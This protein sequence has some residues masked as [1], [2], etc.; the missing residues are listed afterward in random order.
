MTGRS[1]D[2]W[3]L[4]VDFGTTA[5]AAAMT[6]GEKAEVVDIDNAPRMPSMVCWK[7]P[8]NGNPGQ[9]LLGDAAENEAVLAP[10]CAERSPKRKIAQEF[11]LL[12]SER[13]R[14]TDAIGQIFEHVLE[15][16]VP[17]HGG[18]RPDE[19]RV[20]HP[21]RWG[22]GRLARLRAA[23]AAAGFDDPLLVPEP[24]GAAV[25]FAA[26]QLLP[27]DYVAV[28]D[29]GGGT[30]DTA[31]LQRAEIGFEVIGEPGGRDDLG[32]E[33][34]D[35]RLYRY[36]GRRLD[37]EQW[38]TL[39]A[40]DSGRS[41]QRA[42]YDFKQDVRRAKEHLSRYPD[43]TVRT[44]IPDGEDIQVSRAE[45]EALIREDIEST[46]AELER[47]VM[48]AG[49]SVDDLAAIYVAGG[50]S[51]IPLIWRR[52]EERLGKQPSTF[53]DPKA[54]I[55]L[56][57]AR[58]HLPTSP[59]PVDRHETAITGVG[60]TPPTPITGNARPQDTGEGAVTGKPE[61][62]DRASALGAALALVGAVV[63]LLSEVLHN[64]K[65]K[66]LWEVHTQPNS[67]I[68]YPIIVTILALLV[69][70]LSAAG[71][72]RG[73][74]ALLVLATFVAAFLTASL[75]PLVIHGYSHFQVGVWISILGGVLATT[76]SG[77][78]ARRQLGMG[79]ISLDGALSG[80]RAA[81]FA[82]GLGL[83][84]LAGSLFLP[85]RAHHSTWQK[86]S[87]TYYPQAMTVLAAVGISL[88]IL[89]LRGRRRTLGLTAVLSCFLL[90]EAAALVVP[91]IKGLGIGFW[92][93]ILGALIAVV[94]SA[95]TI[96]A[97]SLAD[98]R[99]PEQPPESVAGRL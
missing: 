39:I 82:A 72:R 14:V 79:Q 13:I 11:I 66:N 83:L 94:A 76:G 90:G 18:R 55:A 95:G 99:T 91:H 65:N 85:R 59:E 3:L 9:L 2:A 33:D 51:R 56:G 15:E 92:I 32:G 30:F 89:E 73:R 54:V 31:V 6:V 4:S 53:G 63:I 67:S 17:V 19:L 64:N 21:A 80:A 60:E 38:Q 81:N 23:A 84:V 29:L 58:V 27:G 10:Q 46:V 48:A 87:N 22:E 8:S 24:V 7:E 86:L 97:R 12:G 52:I 96:V 74:P 35:D 98:E 36:L 37:P 57:A 62:P 28:Y 50:S 5:T 41:W 45:F 34:F 78:A 40:P 71:V 77:I 25:Y 49:H 88:V 70:L 68:R 42:H 93:G 1:E 20:T 43:A 69:I 16:A 26:G 47:T 75:V 61:P 44:P